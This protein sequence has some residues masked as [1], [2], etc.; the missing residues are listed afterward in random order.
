[1]TD[2]TAYSA[3]STRA[4][5]TLEPVPLWPVTGARSWQLAW[6]MHVYIFGVVFCALAFN[7]LLHVIRLTRCN[8]LPYAY[9]LGAVDT[10]VFVTGTCR[11]IFL[12]VDPYS[13]N[14]TLYPLVSTLLY[15]TSF[16]SLLCAFTLLFAMLLKLTKVRL[17]LF[18]RS[19]FI[20]AVSAIHAALSQLAFVSLSKFTLHTATTVYITCRVT[21]LLWSTIVLGVY[22][23]LVCRLSNAARSRW[24]QALSRFSP[25][26]FVK[27]EATNERLLPLYLTLLPMTR[28]TAVAA[29]MCMTAAGLQL[30]AVFGVLSPLTVTNPQPWQWW[31]VQSATRLTELLALAAIQH[32]AGLPVSQYNYS[33]YASSSVSSHAAYTTCCWDR[34]AR[35]HKATCCC[36]YGNTDEDGETDRHDEWYMLNSPDYFSKSTLQLHVRADGVT[37]ECCGDSRCA[38]NKSAS[39]LSTAKCAATGPSPKSCSVPSGLASLVFR[40][41]PTVDSPASTRKSPLPTHKPSQGV[42]MLT[43]EN[44]LL[45]FRQAG[46]PEGC[47]LRA[48]VSDDL[49]LGHYPPSLCLTNRISSTASAINH[50]HGGSPSDASVCTDWMGAMWAGYYPRPLPSP[51]PHSTGMGRRS[52]SM[53]TVSRTDKVSDE[54]SWWEEEGGQRLSAILNYHPPSDINLQD[55]IEKALNT[56]HRDRDFDSNLDSDLENDPG[57]TVTVPRSDEPRTSRQRSNSCSSQLSSR[58]YWWA[59][60]RRPRDSKRWRRRFLHN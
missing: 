16:S 37:T 1:M 44:G 20:G 27:S 41:P 18:N 25:C 8:R 13:I 24:R 40:A 56:C 23:S 15:S 49:S 47:G 19:T 52:N 32:A 38:L 53:A 22:M 45:R 12:L 3:W 7:S 5:L 11:G 59:L 10:L 48:G 46:D 58:S 31:A 30:Y 34:P 51:A 36:C 9:Y 17:C 55:S 43:F 35:R 6:E 14:G 29:V 39:M 42:S 21:S 4:R 33:L 57:L 60:Y 54:G 28:Y 50:S 2:N 26:H